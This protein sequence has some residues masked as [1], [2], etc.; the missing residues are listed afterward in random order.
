MLDSRRR[1]NGIDLDAVEQIVDR[2]QK[3]PD[4]A[5]TRLRVKTDWTGQTRSETRVEQLRRDGT[6]VDRGFTILSDEPAELLG[7]NSAP[8]PQELLL[9]ALN[10]CLAVGY[11]AQAA[12][13]GVTLS[14]CRIETEGEFDLRGVLGLDENIPPGSRRLNYV[15]HLDSDAGPELLQEIHEAV[16]GSSPNF[17]NLAQPVQMCGQLA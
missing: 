12:M 13:R 7:T 9:A 8:T 16:M 1:I 6:G 14:S 10:A 15:V 4:R 5:C 17:F 3:W 11:A 2:V